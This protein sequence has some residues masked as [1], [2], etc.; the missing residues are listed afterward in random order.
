MKTC[1][2][3]MRDQN[4]SLPGNGPPQ[5]S[6]ARFAPTNGIES[7]TALPIASPIPESRSSTIE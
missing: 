3:Y 5:I 7:A 6:A 2:M 1:A 4:A